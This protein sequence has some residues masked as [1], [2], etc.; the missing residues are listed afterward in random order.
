[1]MVTIC[2]YCCQCYSGY[3][4]VSSFPE[5]LRSHLRAFALPSVLYLKPGYSRELP[6]S[7]TSG[8]GDLWGKLTA[9]LSERVS[10]TEL[11]SC[12]VKWRSSDF[13]SSLS[14]AP[15][16]VVWIISL[17]HFKAGSFPCRTF[18]ITGTRFMIIL[19][20]NLASSPPKSVCV[21]YF[22]AKKCKALP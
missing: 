11:I 16:T 2:N 1:M 20:L 4:I 8:P 10:Q 17:N 13:M 3:S 15:F 12:H 18:S 14:R 21:E 22:A 9:R 19:Q 6:R 7:W 5:L